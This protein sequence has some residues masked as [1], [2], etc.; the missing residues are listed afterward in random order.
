MVDHSYKFGEKVLDPSCGSG[1]FIIEIFL[2]ILGSNNSPHQ[3]IKAINNLYGFDINPLATFTAKTNLLIIY[4]ENF[5]SI[6]KEQIKLN[7]YLLNSL[8]IEE[9]NHQKREIEPE[10]LFHS[11]DLIIGNPP[12][13]T[14]KDAGATLRT[15]LKKVSK[16]YDIKP[17]AHNITNIEEAVVFFY[18]IPD[19]FLKRNGASKIAFVMPRSILVSS[20]N[21]KARRFEGFKSL[22]IFEFDNSLFNIDF[23]CLFATY[24]PDSGHRN[25]VFKKYPIRCNLYGTETLKLLQQYAL[26]PYVYFEP[27]KGEKYLVKKLIK[28]TRKDS[29][30]ACSLSD[31]YPKFIQGADLLPK[32][33]LYVEIKGNSNKYDTIIINPWISTQAKSVWKQK[34]FSDIRVEKEQIFK[35][36]LSRGLYPYYIELFDIFL[37]LD[38][39]L[40]YN[41]EN[42]GPLSRSHWN[43]IKK[44]Y[45]KHKGD[46]L[47][48]VGVNY[49]NKLCTNGEIKEAQKFPYKVVFPN[50]KTLM[51]AVIEDPD[52]RTF[53]DSTLYYYGTNNKKEAYYLCGMLN[54]SKL[55]ESVKAISDTRHH[56]KRP[57][58][59]NIPKFQNTSQQNLITQLAEKCNTIISEY[60]KNNKNRIT[61][62]K[63]RELIQ[64]T[65]HQIDKIGISILNSGKHMKVIKE[66]LIS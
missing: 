63:I 37:P 15:H 33:L 57:L 65:Q 13:L 8:Y 42:I 39:E 7:I 19:L 43:T 47:F 58:Y 36:T 61:L 54:I 12:W 34:F 32:S 26:E 53:I 2:E 10:K 5:S 30:L 3:K 50:A 1:N 55:Y 25:E 11:F 17:S 60:F 41:L 56:H 22:E 40:K 18:R 38:T 9:K 46:D 6:P 29:L 23:C 66:Y 62:S 27:K 59:F 16:I 4:Y 24:L 45:Q 52:S 21:Q 51:A 20:Q 14:Y 49:R 28:S 64:D 48:E 44:I 35:A 31:Y